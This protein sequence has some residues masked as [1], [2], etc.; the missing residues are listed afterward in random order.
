MAK[1]SVNGQGKRQWP[2]QASMAKATPKFK[3]VHSAELL[4]NC[5]HIPRYRR[6][7]ALDCRRSVA[8]PVAHIRRRW[9]H[10]R[11][12]LRGNSGFARRR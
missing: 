1:A 9:P 11:I 12:L 3:R 5:S 2:R 10:V 7:D 4:Q 8:R 6:R